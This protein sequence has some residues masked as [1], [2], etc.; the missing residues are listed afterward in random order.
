MRVITCATLTFH[1]TTN[2]GALFQTYALQKALESIG[3]WSEVLDYRCPTIET[4]YNARRLSYFFSLKNFIKCI[5]Y[6][7]YIRD[8][9][10]NFLNFTT[11]HIRVSNNIYTPDTIAS[12]NSKYTKFI[13][14]SDQVWNPECMGHD[15][16]FFLVFA[17]SEKR[18]S[19]AASFGWSE[20]SD[21]YLCEIKNI[22]NG[23]SNISLRESSGI[24]I[25]HK[26]IGRDAELVLDPTLLLH[27]EWCE[28]ASSIPRLVEGEYI[29]LYLMKE[30]K[31]IFRLAMD[32]AKSHNMKVVYI[33]DRLLPK[34]GVINKFYTAPIEW[35]NLFYHSQGVFTNSFHGTAFATNF[36]KPLWVELLPAPSKS[37]SR[38]ID[39]LSLLQMEECIIRN[40]SY[41]TA[42]NI[43]YNKVNNILGS[44]RIQS[45]NYLKDIFSK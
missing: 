4:R 17:D 23:F 44:Y 18:N 14:G 5:I 15:L 10:K 20:F 30:T 32:Y 7:S 3:I 45:I 31:S 40:N 25:V 29:V 42:P 43:D 33:N 22:L 6:N 34:F 19:Y 12:S 8:N 27:I 41:P 35:L 26:C 38:L 39:F 11:Q 9:R 24:A 21:K 28:L 16:N 2:Y 13:V 37:N 36:N 1:R